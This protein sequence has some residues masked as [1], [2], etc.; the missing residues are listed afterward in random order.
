MVPVSDTHLDVYKRQT[1]NFPD[2]RVPNLVI[3][4]ESYGIKYT[5][6]TITTSDGVTVPESVLLNITKVANSTIIVAGENVGYTVV[7]NNYG[8]VSYTHL[9]VYKRQLQFQLKHMLI[10]EN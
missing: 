9:D 1:V 7:I 2:L 6:F 4:D 3:K 5:N 8:P 10:L